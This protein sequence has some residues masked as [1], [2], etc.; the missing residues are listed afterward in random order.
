MQCVTMAA[1]SLIEYPHTRKKDGGRMLSELKPRRNKPVKMWIPAHEVESMAL[2]QLKNV[3]DLPHI[4]HHVAA[5]PDVHAGMGATIGTVIAMK[6][7]VIPAAVGVDIGCGMEALSTNLDY[8]KLTEKKLR[9]IRDRILEA[10]PVGF[11]SHDSVSEEVKKLFD[12]W[13]EFDGL[14]PSVHEHKDRAMHQLGTL[15][16]GNHFIELAVDEDFK[17]WVMLHSGSRY[18]GNAIAKVHID[19]AKREPHNMSGLPDKALAWLHRDTQEY[20]QY[21]NDLAWAQRYARLNRVGMVGLIREAVESV[22]PSFQYRDWYG[23]HHNFAQIEEHFGEE[24]VVIRKG[25]ISAREGQMGIIPGAMGAKSFIVRGKGCQM[26]FNSAPHGAGRK[27]SRSKAKKKYDFTELQKTMSGIVCNASK[28]TVD[29]IRH[30]YKNIDKVIGYAEELVE[31][32]HELEQ[33]MNIK[34]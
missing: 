7:A 19:I 17:V 33:I 8:N 15:G 4:F 26:A 34:G 20:A 10:V 23:C 16:G 18:I 2:D 28:S 27:M 12:L 14:H 22:F 9:K 25:A 31:P 32:I 6:D 29:E 5:M 30:A 1:V 24:V 11:N 3:A 21:M 13:R